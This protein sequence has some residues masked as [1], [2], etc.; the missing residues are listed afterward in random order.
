MSRLGKSYRGQTFVPIES[1]AGIAVRDA[2]QKDFDVVDAVPIEVYFRVRGYE[3][4]HVRAAM[5]AYTMV[6]R[7]TL[8]AWD[9]IFATY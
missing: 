1:P 8:E 5:L 3:S 9:R 2:I 6:R 7:A 4:P